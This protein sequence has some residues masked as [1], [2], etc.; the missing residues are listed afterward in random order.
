MVAMSAW[1]DVS[2]ASPLTTV[3]HYSDSAVRETAG[4]QCKAAP[5]FDVAVKR[6]QIGLKRKSLQEMRH[7]LNTAAITVCILASVFTIFF[8]VLTCKQ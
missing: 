7:L 3:S 1:K 2:L 5:H 8:S 4:D 6:K